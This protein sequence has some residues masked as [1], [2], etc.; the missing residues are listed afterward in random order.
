VQPYFID[1]TPKSP[2]IDAH[3]TGEILIEGICI[4]EDVHQHFQ[5]FINWL[6]EYCKTPAKKTVLVIKLAYFNTTTAAV[7]LVV[8]R[9][10]AKLK[11]IG[12]DVVI[13]WYHEEG[14]LEIEDSGH[15]YAGIIDADF[16]VL[17]YVK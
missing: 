12:Y 6:N 7:L 11:L 17:S 8:F 14:D 3:P 13:N 4:P 1:R 16:N 5:E 9:S 15:D 10:V 2:L